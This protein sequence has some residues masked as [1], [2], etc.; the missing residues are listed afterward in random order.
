MSTGIV[1]S[2]EGHDES[3]IDDMKLGTKFWNGVDNVTIRLTQKYWH[4]GC[5]NYKGKILIF[6]EHWAARQKTWQLWLDEENHNTTLDN[7]FF[8]RIKGVTWLMKVDWLRDK[9]IYLINWMKFRQVPCS[10]VT[11]NY[12]LFA[13]WFPSLNF[14]IMVDECLF[15]FLQVQRG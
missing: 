12:H 4:K 8:E 15:S 14:P 10:K 9:M 6:F 2:K 3:H 1:S 13:K 11:N 7:A 5:L